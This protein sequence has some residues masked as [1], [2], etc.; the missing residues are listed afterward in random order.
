MKEL[1]HPFRV[2]SGAGFFGC[3]EPTPRPDWGLTPEAADKAA[4][5][6]GFPAYIAA[7]AAYVSA[8]TVAAAEGREIYDAAGN[9]AGRTAAAESEAAA[10]AAV[11][12]AA[13]ELRAQWDAAFVAPEREAEARAEKMRELALAWRDAGRWDTVWLD[14]G[15]GYTDRDGKPLRAIG[16]MDFPC[17]PDEVQALIRGWYPDELAWVEDRLARKSEEAAAEA[18]RKAAEEAAEAAAAEAAAEEAAKQAAIEAARAAK[19]AA[20]AAKK[21]AQAA[22][23]EEP[24]VGLAGL[25]ALLKGGRG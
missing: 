14:A 7:L 12:S 13:E 9:Y 17:L 4:T 19:R 18:A 16:R 6:P 20:K 8:G 10:R 15:R 11:F 25:V 23:S 5:L 2:E 22:A 21:A 3:G 1:R 24:A